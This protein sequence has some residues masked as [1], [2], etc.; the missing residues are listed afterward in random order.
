MS[1]LK[2]IIIMAVFFSPLAIGQEDLVVIVNKNNPVDEMIRS[3]LIDLYMGKLVAFPNGDAAMPIDQ[4]NDADAREH[5]Y[6]Q[7][8]GRSLSQINAYWARIRFTGRALP[9]TQ[10]SSSE[11][12]IKEVRSNLGAIGYIHR[13]E[14]PDDVKVVFDFAHTN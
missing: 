11:K 2:V 9:P 1:M 13:S 7:L 5:F 10:V 3:E 12:V 6:T 4:T 8:T 14:V